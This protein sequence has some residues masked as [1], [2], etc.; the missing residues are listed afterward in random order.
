MLLEKITEEEDAA[1]MRYRKAFAKRNI[2]D[3]EGV[4]HN[5]EKVFCDNAHFL[6]FW[7]LE[8][9]EL[10]HILGDKLIVKKPFE[11]E[12]PEDYTIGHMT[13]L[14]REN[15]FAINYL[16]DFSV[17]DLVRNKWSY[18]DANI[19]D[20]PIHTGERIT[21]WCRKFVDNEVVN[22]NEQDAAELRASFE[23][24]L[25]LHSQALNQRKIKGNLCLSIH[26]LDYLTMSDP[27]NGWSSCLTWRKGKGECK[28]GTIEMMN[29]PYVVVAYLEAAEPMRLFKGTDFM[30]NQKKWRQLF[31]VEKDNV[32]MGIKGYPYENDSLTT[33][34]LTWLQGL[35]KKAGSKHEWNDIEKISYLDFEMR[36]STDRMYNDIGYTSDESHYIS[37]V[38]DGISIKNLCYSGVSE[39]AMCGG[40]FQNME[41][42]SFLV[43]DSCFTSFQEDD[44]YGGY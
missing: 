2:R 35:V 34:A 10:F 30:W 4:W 5:Q 11:F 12:E 33:E 13:K 32:I 29:S 15:E 43:C 37:V 22:L 23:E 7:K 14:L 19:W 18:Y 21:R 28:Q 41:Q 44:Y 27:H 8:K 40:T 36:L 38:K 25:N 1:L 39:C 16:G 20:V 24:F 31:I 9:R 6:R 3:D 17:S 42:R 26:P